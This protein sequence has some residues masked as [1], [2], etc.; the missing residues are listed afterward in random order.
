MNKSS[1][2]LLSLVLLGAGVAVGW[3][4]PEY[5]AKYGSLV[6]GEKPASVPVKPE[7][8]SAKSSGGQPSGKP[9]RG[10]PVELAV[11]EEI[12]FP[13]GL[14]AIG[15]LRADESTMI[16][17]EIAGR[18]AEINFAEGQPVKQGQLL[19]QLD[20]SVAKAELAQA[21][22]NLALAQS[23]YDRSGR[24]QS[25]GFVS[26]EAREDSQN[27][28]Q[29][30]KAAF[31]LAEAKFNKT[32]IKAPFDGIIGLRDVSVG[33]YVSAGQ[34]IVP[35]ESIKLLKVDFR[36]PERYASDIEINQSLELKV[37]ARPGVVFEGKVYAISPL[38]EEG[39]HSILV[40]ARIDNS[41]GLLLPGMFARVQLITD[42]SMAI[43]VPEAALSP[44]G[45]TQYVYR[46][47]NGKAQSVALAIGERRAGVVE[48]VKGLKAGDL[49]VVAGLQR[50]RNGAPVTPLG[51]PKS[52]TDVATQANESA[53]SLRVNPS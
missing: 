29:L 34:D 2:I 16:S 38:I 43:V 18:V 35:L 8:P 22:A 49:V 40:R 28:L 6:T 9:S 48:V 26:K 47:V 50:I 30:Q 36:L 52:A 3:Y 41:A 15:S 10:L 33:E 24:L 7:K 32:K 1:R 13:R 44:S 53:K 14:S 27:Q 46:I 25:A 42:R 21:Q 5:I 51:K 31:K 19:V 23:R 12:S 4:A 39:G 20:D 37:D 17:A 11:V 45:Q